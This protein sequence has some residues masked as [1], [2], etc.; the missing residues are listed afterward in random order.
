EAEDH[1]ADALALFRASLDARKGPKPPGKDALAEDLQRVWKE[2]G[3]TPEGLAL[4]MDK[5][6]AAEATER[7]WEKPKNPLPAFTLA[8][9]GGKTWK[10]ANLEGKTLLINIWATWCGPCVAEHREFQKLYEKLKDR[11][12]VS[13]MSFNVDEDLGKV[14]PYV[15]EHKYTFPVM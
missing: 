1:K 10:L 9:M 4:L 12:D 5:P 11:P 7:R 14:A 13:V 3:G 8:D 6:K 2:L 15:A